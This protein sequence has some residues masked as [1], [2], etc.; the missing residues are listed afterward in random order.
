MMRATG[1][2]GL[3]R[4][5]LA[6]AIALLGF[7]QRTSTAAEASPPSVL[8]LFSLRSTAPAVHEIER[9]FRDDLEARRGSPI[10]LHVEYLDLPDASSVPYAERLV[11]LLREKYAAR[12]IDVVVTVRSEAL[13][14]LLE[15][16]QDLFPGAA[17]V[18]TDVSRA[19]VAD[20]R[21]PPD[22]TGAFSTNQGQRTVR[23][24]LDLHP[25]ARRVVLVAGSSPS[26]RGS[27]AFART[28]VEDRAPGME[29][30]SLAGLP[31]EEQLLR[32]SRLPPD[33][34]VIFVSYRA[35]SRGRSTVSR[36]VVRLVTRASNAPVYGA[37]ETW[38]GHGIVG[39]DMI[40]YAAVG[41]SAA[42]LTS[43]ILAGESPSAIAPVE[44]PAS[45]YEFDWRQ[46]QRWRIDETRLPAGGEVLFREK[47]L[48]SEYPG[49]MLVAIGLLLGQALLIAALLVE[50]RSRVRAQAELREAEERYRT[51]AE[52]THDWE[53]WRRPDGSLAFVSP[54]CARVTGHAAVE[55]YRR[56]ALLAEL[57]VEEDRPLWLAHDQLA[58]DQEC[59]AGAP[60]SQL[61]FRIRDAQGRERFI[62][63]LC[64]PVTGEDGSFLGVRGSNRD[65]TD[66][67]R[68]EQELRTALAEIGRLRERL[69]A[70]NTYLREL[71]EP[72]PG[73]E[74]IVG[75]S[76][77]L[78]YVMSKVHQ[79]APTSSTVLL[80]GET[81][82]GK[83]LVAHALHNLSP[84][85]ARPWSSSTALRCLHRSSRA[86]SSVT[87]RAPSPAPSPCAR[88]ASRSP[89]AARSSSTR[90]ASCRSSCRPSCCA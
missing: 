5:R 56:P 12:R 8:L 78:R 71:V 62:D 31:L 21:L 76:D 69:E 42:L 7:G 26:D 55:F 67:K 44:Q 86:S 47:T 24:A 27:E 35:D 17:V 75:R 20:L 40:R 82:V 30:L 85:R 1:G 84:R 36:D 53:F 32:L 11:A 25:Q 70:D 46:L 43:R 77:V 87:R 89:T 41:E 49:R 16:R 61:E 10:D 34:V 60:G 29:V 64:S 13:H 65:V 28:L 6:L 66:K 74:G 72:E 18:F 2:Q 33:S 4:I 9:G 52:F 3:L 88:D 59:L 80:Q 50:R 57:V 37:A 83:E 38:L 22:V 68:S 79:V 81:G 63:H 14:F 23:V 58:H 19:G 73:F 48:W 39:G 45:H 90:S 54:S 15:H 51:V